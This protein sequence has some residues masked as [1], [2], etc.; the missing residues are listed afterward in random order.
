MCPKRT[1]HEL[2]HNLVSALQ[3]H[4]RHS[5]SPPLA[6]V[7]PLT[8]QGYPLPLH[9]C[10]ICRKTHILTRKRRACQL[11][12]EADLWSIKPP[13]R[14]S[15]CELK[16]KLISPARPIFFVLPLNVGD[17]SFKHP[18]VLCR[19]FWT[20]GSVGLMFS[21]VQYRIHAK[22][23]SCERLSESYRKSFCS[24]H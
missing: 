2:K 3:N 16:L 9:L 10:W 4:G 6:I 11:N 21:Q 18:R 1:G 5:I 17:L 8:P 14:R 23:P 22:S 15:H 7:A 20:S 13:T 19:Y 12:L 24:H